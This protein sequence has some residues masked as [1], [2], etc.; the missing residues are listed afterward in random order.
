MR[1]LITLGALLRLS[2]LDKQP[3]WIE[4]LLAGP[5]LLVDERPPVRFDRAG[6]N[7]PLGK[8]G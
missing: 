5:S 1:N 8:E 6:A 2:E 3:L 4:V 7:D